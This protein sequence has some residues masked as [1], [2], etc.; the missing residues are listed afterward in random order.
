MIFLE[1]LRASSLFYLHPF[2]LDCYHVLDQVRYE[3]S[4]SSEF[5]MP[6][7]KLKWGL[8]EYILLSFWIPPEGT[9]ARVTL[10]VTSLLTLTTQVELWNKKLWNLRHSSMIFSK[11]RACNPS[12]LS[13]R[14]P[15]RRPS[16]SGS[17]LALSLSSSGSNY[18][19]I[20]TDLPTHRN[21]SFFFT[22]KSSHLCSL[23]EFAVINALLDFPKTR[24]R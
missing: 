15:I 13:R 7:I 14:S 3:M 24:T 2:C 1:R 8:N 19:I 10:G 20:L 6:S 12:R 18:L 11:P 22:H 4:T 9:P 21:K 5:M 17:P 16:T 23:M